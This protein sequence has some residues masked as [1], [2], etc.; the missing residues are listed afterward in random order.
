[1][2][3]AELDTEPMGVELINTI[4][5]LT[6]LPIESVQSEMDHI[7]KRSGQNA[8]ELTLTQLREALL[9]YLETFGENLDTSQ[10]W[11]DSSSDSE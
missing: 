5:S 4:V 3:V 2:K 1:M 7:I 10:N 6:G 8:E 11:P 9:T